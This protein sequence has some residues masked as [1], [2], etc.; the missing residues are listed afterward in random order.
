MNENRNTFILKKINEEGKVSVTELANELNVSE[1]TIRRDLIELEAEHLLKRVYG[2]AI[3]ATGRSYEPPFMIRSESEVE[4]KVKIG[5]FAASLVENGDSL[6]IDIGSTTYEIAKNLTVKKNLTII[7]TGLYIANLFLNKPDIRTI[8]PGG[9]IRHG[10]GSLTGQLTAQAFEGLFVDKLFLAMGGISSQAGCT[11][12][13]W[14]DCMVKQS[15][16][17]SAK[18]VIAVADA[19]KFEVI[20]F[21]KICPLS[22][23]KRLITNKI[24]PNGL[25]Q[26]LK[27]E[28]IQI[29]VV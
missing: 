20:A 15:M 19:T 7:T 3:S 4:A 23:I 6:A 25:F 8:L 29:D 21:A 12:Y 18:E 24:P 9:I 10:E 1:M 11:E 28:R 27:N 17:K 5:K 16:I 22:S 2:G 13:N 26:A 14:E